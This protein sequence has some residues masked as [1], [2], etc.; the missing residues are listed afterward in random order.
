MSR[1]LRQRLRWTSLLWVP[2]LSS[3]A[4]PS[5]AIARSQ[6]ELPAVVAP[7]ESLSGS[8]I[9][10]RIE[11]LRSKLHDLTHGTLLGKLRVGMTVHDAHSGEEVFALNAESPFN[12]ASNTK[13]FTTAAA[14]S[15]LGADFH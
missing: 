9:S 15:V 3:V 10:S 12:P 14:L 4:V 1:G 8:G 2:V 5:P 7:A 13:I 11:T 6:P